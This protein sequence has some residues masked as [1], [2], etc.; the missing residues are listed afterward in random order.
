[1]RGF[2]IATVIAFLLLS[3]TASA[4]VLR[5]DDRETIVM[6]I[7][8]HLRTEYV[9]AEVGQHAASQLEEDLNGGRF[10]DMV[11]SEAF[12]E[13]LSERLQ[14][15]TKDGHLNVEFSAKALSLADAGDAF[16][17]LEMEKYYGA[18]LNFGVQTA[19]RIDRNIG[20]LDLR[21]FA[22]TS[23][24]GETVAAAMNV[25]ANTDALVI[26]LRKNGGGIGDMADFVA[27]YLF[28]ETRHPLT[29]T[30]DRPTDT[31][32]QR[33]TQAF[34]PGQRFGPDKPVYVLISAAT[35]SAAEAFAYNLQTLERATIVGETSAGGAHPFEY[36]AIHPHF[37][38]WSVTAK[39]VNP[40]TGTNWQG[41]GVQPDVQVPSDDALEA[42]IDL[43]VE[44]I[45]I[46]S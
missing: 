19:G 46:E 35:F 36:K 17:A 5:N 21:V 7:I 31:L 28:D 34:V 27:S 32:T 30:Y 6:H 38:L 26:D 3:T 42:A 24:G 9:D 8:D 44:D 2:A 1:M 16:G 33:Y 4:H 41:V 29:G 23:M 11:G 15:L 45:R 37:V 25:V 18:H 22:P 39:S 13:R 14:E 12:A 10:D 20:Y 40:I 43:I